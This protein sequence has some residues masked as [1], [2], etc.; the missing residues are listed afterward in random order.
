MSQPINLNRVRKARARADKKA[1]AD[2][3]AVLHGLPKA[4]RLAAQK[5]AA[6]SSAQH[7]AHNRAIPQ[8][9]Q[10]PSPKKQD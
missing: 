7:E 10:N 2:A 4:A 6:R 8:K 3:N 9:S 1:R 5:E